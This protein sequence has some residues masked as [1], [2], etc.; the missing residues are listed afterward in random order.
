MQLE[1]PVRPLHRLKPHGRITTSRRSCADSVRW[2]SRH[3]RHFVGRFVNSSAD[4]CF[5][6]LV[7]VVAGYTMARD[8]LCSAKELD[9]RF[10]SRNPIRQ[11]IQVSAEGH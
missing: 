1:A 10:G 4:D 5:C 9:R 7:G 3:R 8:R 11:R 6:A 2:D